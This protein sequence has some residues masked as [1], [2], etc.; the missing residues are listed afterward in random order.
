M[1][2]FGRHSNRGSRRATREARLSG[3]SPGRLWLLFLAPLALLAF[4]G[5]AGASVHWSFETE[6]GPSFQGWSQIADPGNAG[7]GIAYRPQVD[8]RPHNP[9]GRGFLSSGETDESGVESDAFT[10]VWQSPSFTVRAPFASLLVRATTS[11]FTDRRQGTWVAVCAASPESPRGC[12]ELTRF[13]ARENSA[14]FRLETLDLSALRGRTVFLQVVDESPTRR[15]AVDNVR[16][17]APLMPPDFTGQARARG[18]RLNWEPAPDSAQVSRYVIARAPRASGPWRGAGQVGCRA[19]RCATT[20]FDRSASVD[21][22]WHYRVVAVDRTGARSEA[23]RAR[24]RSFARHFSRGNSRVYRGE[25]LTA[26]AFPVGGIGSS[27]ILH[28]GDARRNQGLIFNAYGNQHGRTEYMV[29]NSFFAIR[30]VRGGGRPVV[31]ALQTVPEGPFARMGSLQF[32]GQF[33]FARYDFQDAGLPVR[34]SHLVHSPTIPG[35]ARDSAIPVALY[36]T[37]L[38]NPGPR[39]VR[40]SLLATQQNAAGLDGESEVE[41]D[42]RRRHPGYGSNQNRV[43]R[44]GART[45]LELTGDAGSMAL[46][47]PGGNVSGAASWGSL[48]QLYRGFAGQ[49]RV[50]GPAEAASPEDGITVDGALSRTIVVPARSTRSIRTTLSWNFPERSRIFGGNG[51]QYSN[52]WADANAVDDY[53]FANQRRL[54][55]QTRRFHQAL[56]GSAL[57]R[58]VLDRLSGNIA[59]LRSPSTF[60]AANGFFGGWEGWGCCWNM[61]T[62]VWHYAQTHARLWPGIGR[63]FESQWLDEVTPEGLIPYR[64]DRYEFAIDG[65][66]GVV[67]ASYRD[68]LSAPDGRWLAENWDAIARAMDYVIEQ[69]DPDRDGV[70]GGTALTTLDFPQTLDGPWIGGLY[71]SALE[72][73]SRMAGLSGDA[74]RASAYRQLAAS[75]R[76]TQSQRYWRNGYF[77]EVADPDPSIRSQANGLDIDML[78]GHWWG[79]QLG[80][81][82]LYPRPRMKAALTRLYQENFSPRL[83]GSNPYESYPMIPPS[84][85]FAGPEDG[86]MVATT[87]PDEGEPRAKTQYW[88]EVWTGREYTAAATM[89]GQGNVRQGLEVVKAVDDRHDG[90][91]R[92]EP[93]MSAGPPVAWLETCHVGEGTGNPFGD[94]ECGNWYGRALSGWSVLLA[95]QG[96]HHDSPAGLLRFAPPYRPT[97]HRSFFTAGDAWGQFAQRRNGRRF[98]A[99]LRVDRGAVRL[100]R[101]ELARVGRGL[102]GAVRVRVDGRRV[103]GARARAANGQVVAAL[104][105]GLVLR[106]GS[107]LTLEAARR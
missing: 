71:I 107:R 21:R 46:T 70:L 96:F 78:L 92:N 101:L 59:T 37:R 15:I 67:L 81:P 53:V 105:R 22:D 65:Q 72:A 76:A 52:W 84:R 54:S 40:V 4:A 27:G 45:R 8:V 80:L 68:H 16:V 89:I 23:N 50:A 56:Y 87:W 9:E 2:I 44:H 95:L 42:D 1:G 88:S 48:E 6:T 18:V 103:P 36:E 98:T 85:V 57:P 63:R 17:N 19:G 75:G 7:P 34:V 104:N 61:P 41:G 73:A 100:N 49:G 47:M 43:A 90:R 102:R 82:A 51:V 94:D 66:L 79:S 29:P 28:L 60:W 26:I 55:G 74:D 13:D 99:V 30:A 12:E 83:T 20:F 91:L 35:N 86:G 58:F 39:P 10:G 11:S 3:V 62:H 14:N 69:N 64:Y 24:V 5:S 32:R 38:T 97:A 77:T 106:A 31:R 93:F 25:N 33:P